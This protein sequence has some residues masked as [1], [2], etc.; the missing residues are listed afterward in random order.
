[1]YFLFCFLLSLRRHVALL[2]QV[3]GAGCSVT[4]VTVFFPRS[5]MGCFRVAENDKYYFISTFIVLTL[6]LDTPTYPDFKN[7]IKLHN[8]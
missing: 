7:A 1:M 6:I 3:L 8:E 2:S 5:L 4:K